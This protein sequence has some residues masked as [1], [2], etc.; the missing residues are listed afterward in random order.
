[1][2]PAAIAR[3]TPPP[4]LDADPVDLRAAAV[5]TEIDPPAIGENCGS[6]SMLEEVASR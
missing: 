2:T 3:V 6:V 4:P 5:L 1:M